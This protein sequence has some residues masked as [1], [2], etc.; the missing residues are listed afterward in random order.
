M[1]RIDITR[2]RTD[3]ES[4]RSR[5]EFYL[6]APGFVN[7]VLG[8]RVPLGSRKDLVTLRDKINKHLES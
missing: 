2:K 5:E 8:V 7:T 4:G 1:K 6:L 3:H